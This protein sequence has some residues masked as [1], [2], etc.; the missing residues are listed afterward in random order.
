M[1][2]GLCT[3]DMLPG[4]MPRL[5]ASALGSDVCVLRADCASA[6][7]DPDP[8]PTAVTVAS[9]LATVL[10]VVMDVLCRPRMVARPAMSTSG[11]ASETTDE[12]E[13]VRVRVKLVL[14]VD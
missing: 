6:D 4:L 8:K 13:R 12:L 14:L 7:P 3:K 9:M 11:A 5:V 2:S 1:T 10:V